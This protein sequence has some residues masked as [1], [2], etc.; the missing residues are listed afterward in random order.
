[1]RELITCPY[2]RGAGSPGSPPPPPPPPPP[3]CG[4][5]PPWGRASLS[6]LAAGAGS[7]TAGC[8]AVGAARRAA[9]PGTQPATS[10]RS[11]AVRNLMRLSLG[12]TAGAAFA[13]EGGA[14]LRGRG[15]RLA[16]EDR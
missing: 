2:G 13:E 4:P 16:S 3:A 11:P 7:V 10:R 12:F 15:G 14:P 6:G 1:M 8:A 9:T 5:G